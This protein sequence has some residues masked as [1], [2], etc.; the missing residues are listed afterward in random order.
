MR[1][2]WCFAVLAI[3]APEF[4]AGCD[5]GTPIVPLPLPDAGHDGGVD[6]GGADA[7]APDAGRCGD[8]VCASPESCT[9]C[10][11]DCLVC[12]GTCTGTGTFVGCRGNGCAVCLEKVSGYTRY[13]TNHQSCGKNANCQGGYFTCSTMCPA[14][15]PADL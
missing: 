15:A 13:F 7:G 5:C 2:L 4:R 3:A 1:P 12:L 9:V 14:P 11:S 8:G 10:S 6:A